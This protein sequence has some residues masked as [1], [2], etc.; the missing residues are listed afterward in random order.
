[1]KNV[2]RKARLLF[3][4][5]RRDFDRFHVNVG[6][7]VPDRL[8]VVSLGL[9]PPFDDDVF[10]DFRKPFLVADVA[11]IL[12][13]IFDLS[14][15]HDVGRE[16]EISF[17]LVIQDLRRCKNFEMLAR[18]VV[19]G[20]LDELIICRAVGKLELRD[21]LAEQGQEGVGLV[22]NADRAHLFIGF[23]GEQARNNRENGN[24]RR[25]H[26]QAD[27]E[28]FCLHTFQEFPFRDPERFILHVRPPLHERCSSPATVF[29]MFEILDE[30]ERRPRQK[31]SRQVP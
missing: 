6:R 2:S 27:D 4:S 3:L 21:A 14:F 22:D 23:R 19:V 28:R 24:D 30:R 1:M 25:H 7:E 8:R 13:A 18:T 15:L 9:E 31:N 16:K 5:L 12:R 17:D 10:E 29:R 26:E 11:D 20:D